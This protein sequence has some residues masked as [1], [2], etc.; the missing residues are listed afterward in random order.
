ML[1]CVYTC[2]V[3]DSVQVLLVGE[4][5]GGAL[6]EGEEGSCSV[7]VVGGEHHHDP[8]QMLALRYAHRA[9]ALSRIHLVGNTISRCT[10]MELYVFNTPVIS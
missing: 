10:Y 8:H 9:A 7:G 3:A 5:N 1:E 4:I 2:R 6:V